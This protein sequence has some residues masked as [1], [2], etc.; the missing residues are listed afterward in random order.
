MLGDDESLSTLLIAADDDNWYIANSWL[1]ESA[2][3]CFRAGAQ[4]PPDE[5]EGF[6]QSKTRPRKLNHRSASVHANVSVSYS[7]DELCYFVA[8]V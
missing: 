4:R 2:V 3:L 6:N 1:A 8:K 5:T 7:S